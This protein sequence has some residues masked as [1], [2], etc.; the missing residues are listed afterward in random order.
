MGCEE[1]V[2]VETDRRCSGRRECEV[3]IPDAVFDAFKPC[4][5]E[6][7]TYFEAEYT[8]IGGGYRI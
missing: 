1:D 2:L 5:I 3:R 6:F 7:K 4:P 8:C